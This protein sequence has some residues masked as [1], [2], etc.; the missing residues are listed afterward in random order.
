MDAKRLTQM[1]FDRPTVGDLVKQHSRR[2]SE[3]KIQEMTVA[4]NSDPSTM[5]SD[6]KAHVPVKSK[7]KSVF[8]RVTVSAL[9][10]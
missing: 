9:G 4:S 3:M 2:G 5:R 6:Q 8:Q 10:D 1:Y 7:S